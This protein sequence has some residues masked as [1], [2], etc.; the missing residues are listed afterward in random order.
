MDGLN[1]EFFGGADKNNT[2]PVDEAKKDPGE[3]GD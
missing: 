1:Y 2:Y 3:V